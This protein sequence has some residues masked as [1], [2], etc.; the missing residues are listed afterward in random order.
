[1]LRIALVGN[2]ASGKTSVEAYLVELGYN[3]LDTDLVCHE[4]L[5]SSEAVKEAFCDYDVFENGGISR[6]KLG[7]L[8]FTDQELK[9]QLENLLYPDLIEKIRTFFEEKSNE[10]LCFVAIPLLFEA[11]MENLFDKIVFIY[12]DDEIR[13]KRLILRNNYTEEYAKIRMD[14]QLSQEE[15]VLKSD[16]VLKNEGSFE[17]LKTEV[18]R[19]IEQIR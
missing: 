13:M 11:G 19:L 4:L 15:K 12:C 2:I 3:V 16:F 1:M 17:D 5:Q 7:K 10:N 8:I 14:S 18:K 9:N 6:E